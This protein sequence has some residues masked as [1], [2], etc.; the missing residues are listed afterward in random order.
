MEIDGC[1]GVSPFNKGDMIKLDRGRTLN[2]FLFPKSVSS[3][4]MHMR[5]VDR[6]PITSTVPISIIFSKASDFQC[7]RIAVYLGHSWQTVCITLRNLN[8][9]LHV[10]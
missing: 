1:H 4:F 10:Q 6:F 2:H 3:F 5:E 9:T 8:V 7:V